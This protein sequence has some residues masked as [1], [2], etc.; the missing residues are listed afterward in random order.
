M[1]LVALT[2]EPEVK[3]RLEFAGSHCNYG[4]DAMVITE[5]GSEYCALYPEAGG[6]LRYDHQCK[7]P[8]RDPACIE[9]HGGAE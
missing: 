5:D 4:C 7:L 2:Q 6:R 3:V 9:A 8:H 1:T